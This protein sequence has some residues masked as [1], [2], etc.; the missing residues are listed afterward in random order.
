MS[1]ETDAVADHVDKA[2]FL[3]RLRV[4]FAERI[5]HVAV[6]G[7]RIEGLSREGAV[8]R[9]PCRPE[10]IGDTLRG[11]IHT[12]VVTSLVDSVCGLAVSARIGAP[13]A[14]ATL[15]LRVDYLRPS[16]GDADLLCRAECYRLTAH[17]A[18]VRARVWQDDPDAPVAEGLATFMRTPNRP[19]LSAR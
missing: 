16:H 2:A 3:E 12:G 1:A 11:V 14:V 7:I 13:Q 17:V 8:A 5:P 10:F 15:D 19:L 4:G 9:L 6:M 18:F